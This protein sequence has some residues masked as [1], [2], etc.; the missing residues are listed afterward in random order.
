MRVLFDE[1]VPTVLR[2]LFIGHEVITVTEQG[3]SGT[4]NGKLLKLASEGFDVFITVD[5]NL[6][7][8]R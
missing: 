2:N 5:K 8:C 1:C 4:K 6:L 3:W 7:I